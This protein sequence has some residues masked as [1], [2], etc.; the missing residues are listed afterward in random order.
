NQDVI[1]NTR[2]DHH[3]SDFWKKL[4]YRVVGVDPSV[5]SKPNDECGIVVVGSTGERKLYKR[6]GYVL[7]DASILGS[8]DKWAARAV[9]M[10]R[11]YRAVIVAE[12]NQGG[13][14]VKM[15]IQ[16]IDNKVPVTLVRSNAGKMARAEPV[17]L[18]YERGR[19]HHLDWF[20]EL[21]AQLTS[22]APDQ[23]MASPDR[24]DAC[25]HALTALLV[26]PPKQWVSGIRSIV[27]GDG[28]ALDI[29]DHDPLPAITAPSNRSKDV[30]SDKARFADVEGVRYE[31][32]LPHDQQ[33]IDKA[34]VSKQRKLKQRPLS[35][36]VGR[37]SV[38]G[39]SYNPPITR[40]RRY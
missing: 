7:E 39:R 27:P 35:V 3:E 18:A 33:E 37:G 29:K 36:G 15:V 40:S 30:S 13:E 21:E 32:V 24:L 10:A 34:D 28:R 6:E 20:T 38:R 5:S 16:A 4:P 22:W 31:D 14:M 23:G 9:E 11:K 8:P 25:V 17:G 1:D 2:E 19:V 26:N 12:D